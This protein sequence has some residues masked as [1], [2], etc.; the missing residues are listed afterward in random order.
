MGTP[1]HRVSAIE[2]PAIHRSVVHGDLLHDGLAPLHLT[3]LTVLRT[4]G[5]RLWTADLTFELRARGISAAVTSA[6][7]R[8]LVSAGL[9]RGPLTRALAYELTVAGWDTVR[10]R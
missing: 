8:E 10:P 7:L 5:G 2:S 1:M 3:I 4:C 9:V 6:A